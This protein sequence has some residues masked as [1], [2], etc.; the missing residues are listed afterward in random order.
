MYR[1]TRPSAAKRSRRP[2]RLA[3][4]R[5][6][7]RLVM[8]IA[9]LALAAVSLPQFADVARSISRP[10]PEQGSGCRVLSV[11]DGDTVTLWCPGTGAQ[12]A[13]LTGFDTPEVFS[14]GCT[15]EWRRGVQAAWALRRMLWAADEVRV[16]RGGTD[17]YGRTLAAVFLDGEPVARRMIAEGHAR[18]YSGGPRAGWCA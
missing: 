11:I 7:L 9:A 8:G 6:Y 4:P 18:P 12:R 3:D 1:E 15:A 17:R 5:I 13:R 14:P 10:V 16:V 2:A